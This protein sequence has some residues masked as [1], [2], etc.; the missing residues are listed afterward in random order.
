M[1]YA[2]G[3]LFDIVMSGQMTRAEINCVFR[4]I[5][6]GVNYLHGMGLAH[7]DLKLDNCLMTEKNVV[8][9]IDLGCA[10]VFHYPGKAPTKATG[11][12]GSDPYMAPEMLS[13]NPYDP[14]KVDVWSIAIIYLCMILRRFPWKVANPTNDV[15]FRR[16]FDVHPELNVQ[17][18][19][20]ALPSLSSPIVVVPQVS[21]SKGLASI[22][23]SHET[24]SPPALTDGTLALPADSIF[25]RLPREA[26]SALK[27]MMHIEPYGRCT[28]PDLLIGTGKTRRLACK[29]RGSSCGGEVG[30]G[31][32]GPVEE[33]DDGD[34]WIKSVVYC[35]LPWCTP[36]HTH[37]NLHVEEK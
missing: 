15:S 32:C 3:D 37:V 19:H 21:T 1:E 5:I 31:V 12:V 9:I 4:Q 35:S 29:W 23:G 14:Q 26:R 28:L 10:T 25:R 22:S 8:K 33:V 30:G 2:P 7:R 18:A 11:I 16:F 13:G 17:P 24:Q 34:T 36:D 20:I 27:R 6:E